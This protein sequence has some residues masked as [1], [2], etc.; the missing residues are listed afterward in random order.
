MQE[1][2]RQFIEVALWSLAYYLQS[3]VVELPLHSYFL[4]VQFLDLKRITETLTAGTVS[5]QL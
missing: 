3:Y 1:L 2:S 5:N 4:S